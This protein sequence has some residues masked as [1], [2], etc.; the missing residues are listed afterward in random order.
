MQKNQADKPIWKTDPLYPPLLRQI[1]KAPAR[2][3]WKGQQLDPTDKYFAIVG[4]RHPT[5]YGEQIAEEFA[6]EIAYAGFTIVSGLAYGIDAIAHKTALNSGGRTVAVLGAGLSHIG[7][8]SNIPLAKQ[9]QQSGTIIT[10]Y[11]ANEPPYKSNFPERNRIIAG[12][13]FA[14]LVIEAPEKSGALITARHALE[15]GREVFAIPGNVT[16]GASQGCNRLLRDSGAHI[17]TCVED[18]FNQLEIKQ[19]YEAARIKHPLSEDEE[20]IYA[21]LKK[22]PL[23]IDALTEQ[24]KL[25]T[26]RVSVVLSLL[27]LK[28]LITLSGPYALVTR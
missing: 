17:T 15:A 20:T 1:K 7:P 6:R 14:T 9:I 18:I 3:F 28:G 27:E 8:P 4:T 26:P 23:S 11:E 19:G 16:Q 24:S 13:S 10:E 22:S 21:L 25:P 12:M 2:L 5:P